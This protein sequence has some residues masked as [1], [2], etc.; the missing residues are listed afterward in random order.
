MEVTRIR[1]LALAVSVEKSGGRSVKSIT[2]GMLGALGV[3]DGGPCCMPETA[4]I[5]VCRTV[6]S[7]VGVMAVENV[8]SLGDTSEESFSG[9]GTDG[10]GAELTGVGPGS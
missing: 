4:S 8:G 10:G 7:A 5:Q 6:R 1:S 2:S 9:V 3:A